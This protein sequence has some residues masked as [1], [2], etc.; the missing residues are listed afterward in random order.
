[1]KTLFAYYLH[2]SIILAHHVKP[3]R[4]VLQAGN[5]LL[6]K[7]VVR[8][9]ERDG[10]KAWQ[11]FWLPAFAKFGRSRAPYLAK[12]M[13]IDI[14]DPKSLGSYHD[15]EDPILGVEGHWET[16]ENGHPV[17]VETACVVCDAL[18]AA[19]ENKQCRA[20]FCRH[21]VAAMEQNT[22]EALNPDYRVEIH[23]LMTEDAEVCRFVHK[24]EIK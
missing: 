12:K 17:R 18:K 4:K 16:T 23:D 14:N 3:F 24:I 10:L 11:S 1:M 9:Y 21:V 6:I 19:T 13:A 2:Y 22:G 7:L 15:F 20:D 8:Q 5:T